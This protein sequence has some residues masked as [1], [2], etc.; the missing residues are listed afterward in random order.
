LL[1][2]KYEGPVY[3]INPRESRLFNKRVYPSLKDVPGTVDLAFVTTP[4]SI[5]PHVIKDCIDKGVGAIVV[6]SSGFRE[7]GAVGAKLE[8]RI[9]ELARGAQIPMVGPNTMGIVSTSVSLYA[10]GASVR[11]APGSISFVSQSGNLGTQLLSWAEERGIGIS[12]FVGSGNE[13][14]LTATD[15]LRFLIK[16]PD[17]RIILLYLEGAGGG[18]EFLRV[19]REGSRLKPII[20]LKAGRTDAGRRAA[21]SHSGAMSVEASVLS[22]ALTQS[23]VIQVRN[24]SELLNLAAGFAHL[25]IPKGPRVGVISL[26]GGWGVV[27]AD[28]CNE[29]RLD[30]PPLPKHVIKRLDNLLPSFWSRANPIDLVGQFDGDLYLRVIED[31]AREDTIDALIVLGIIGIVEFAKRSFIWTCNL[32]KAFSEEQME[33]VLQSIGE[34]ERDVM[35]HMAD[36][37]KET[38]KPIIGV[39]MSAKQL[40]EVVNLDDGVSLMTYSTPEKAVSV[41]AKLMEFGRLRRTLRR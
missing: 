38:R 15:F 30:L 20:V 36:L 31:L 5:V 33:A 16:D 14:D 37:M 40:D 2:G 10:T 7:T 6:I 35:M 25:P 1:S 41:L 22:G 39:S 28:E 3:P 27:T 11:P 8:K 4:A 23:G 32:S 19:A 9:V 13:G 17:T 29:A 24:P 26:G 34:M 18:R 12:K 21:L